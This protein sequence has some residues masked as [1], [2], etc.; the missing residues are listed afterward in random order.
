[1]KKRFVILLAVVLGVVI[2]SLLASRSSR[3]EPRYQGKPLSYWFGEYC[4]YGYS[5]SPGEERGNRALKALRAIGTN[6]VPFLVV[7]TFSTNQDSPLT[8]NLVPLL[9]KLG[10]PEFIPADDRRAAAFQAVFEIKPPAD[11]LLPLLAPALRSSDEANR[12]AALY[13]LGAIG[14]GAE[15]TVPHLI[16]GLQSTNAS[17]RVAAVGAAASLGLPVKA[18]IPELIEILKR[19]DQGAA[20]YY[21]GAFG[22]EPSMHV[23]AAIALRSFGTNA[24]A[25]IPVLLETQ[26]EQWIT[27]WTAATAALM[28]IG[29]EPSI[30]EAEVV[31]KMNST[32][33]D[34]R[35]D[36]TTY[37]L[38]CLD[39]TNALALNVL[40]EISHS[41][42]RWREQAIQRLGKAGVAAEFAIPALRALAADDDRRVRD[43]AQFAL[44]NIEAAVATNHS[45]AK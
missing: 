22:G 3:R 6:A 25:A 15:V 44:E 19:P 27:A 45:G 9:S 12:A 16:A 13:M 14:N 24:A 18:V 37:F 36:A 34:C 40:I 17:E 26:K 7:Q 30:A 31:N 21:P 41:N 8:T 1:M 5:R 4:R 28:K 32:N 33:D 38:D 42:S 43:S 10:L 23:A 11:A 35:F 20:R 39:P 29:S 2:A